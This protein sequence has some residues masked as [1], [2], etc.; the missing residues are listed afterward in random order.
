MLDNLDNPDNFRDSL[1]ELS[2]AFDEA[3]ARTMIRPFLHGL[4]PET[5]EL[6]DRI[7]V[8]AEEIEARTLLNQVITSRDDGIIEMNFSRIPTSPGESWSSTF[9]FQLLRD[10]VSEDPNGQAM[11][12]RNFSTT[13]SYE[14]LSTILSDILRL[15]DIVRPHRNGEDAGIE[16]SS[17][18]DQ[19]Y[20]ALVEAL[21]DIPVLSP[22]DRDIPQAVQDA[23]FYTLNRDISMQFF[24]GRIA[25]GDGY[26]GDLFEYDRQMLQALL[27]LDGKYNGSLDGDWGPATEHAVFEFGLENRLPENLDIDIDRI[28]THRDYRNADDLLDLRRRL[29]DGAGIWLGESPELI[30][31]GLRIIFSQDAAEDVL[32]ER[33]LEGS[34]ISNMRN[35][36]QDD[37][38]IIE[39]AFERVGQFTQGGTMSNQPS[40]SYNSLEQSVLSY[41]IENLDGLDFQ[42]RREILWFFGP[43][44][45]AQRLSGYGDGYGYHDDTHITV[46]PPAIMNEDELLPNSDFGMRR[47][48][49]FGYNRAHLGTDYPIYLRDLPLT[50]NA[51]AIV[52]HAGPN[53]GF[54]NEVV[55]QFSDIHGNPILIERRAHLDSLNVSTGD[56]VMPDEILGVAGQTGRVA[57]AHLHYETYLQH[58]DGNFYAVDPELVF[59][60]NINDQ[61]IRDAIITMTHGLDANG[62]LNPLMLREFRPHRR[63]IEPSYE[64]HILAWEELRPGTVESS[65]HIL[66][67]QRYDFGDGIRAQAPGGAPTGG[68]PFANHAAVPDI[69]N[70]IGAYGQIFGIP[71]NPEAILLGYADQHGLGGS[72]DIDTPQSWLGVLGHMRGQLCESS[73]IEQISSIN[74]SSDSDLRGALQ[75]VIDDFCTYT[76]GQNG[77][78]L[79]N[80]NDNDHSVDFDALRQSFVDRLIKASGLGQNLGEEPEQ[81]PPTPGSPTAP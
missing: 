42:Q 54:G 20:A 67:E 75:V 23:V 2:N 38:Q 22:Q 77:F 63:S 31:D 58:S 10:L 70:T 25:S 56:N 14:E 40:A 48:P 57:G 65:P 4:S 39:R 27:S 74:E 8:S 36:N 51:P 35:L 50:S 33:L 78:D 18:S 30:R 76:P 15:S 52:I 28:L 5:E 29:Y 80:G 9:E 44:N 19:E 13:S 66:D 68:L 61:D 37:S 45:I 59:T 79:F 6:F 26:N 81:A 12:A 53:G 62:E 34:F 55:T 72:F 24:L 17:L 43:E 71:G 21:I 60:Y 16:L 47:H 46:A 32:R 69:E 7:V 73:V 3:G 41:F 64:D 49:V 1:I 11:G